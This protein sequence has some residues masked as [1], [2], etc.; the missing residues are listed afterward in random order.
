MSLSSQ[1]AAIVLHL[2]L[3]LRELSL[4]DQPMASVEKNKC[5]LLLFWKPSLGSEYSDEE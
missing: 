2:D 4:A 5:L 1:V 3:E